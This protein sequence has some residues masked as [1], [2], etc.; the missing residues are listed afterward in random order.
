M[1]DARS[2]DNLITILKADS[3]IITL[4][5]NRVYIGHAP[6]SAVL[7]FIVATLTGSDELQVLNGT[8]G[9]R[10][11]EYDIDCAAARSV[12]AENISGAVRAALTNYTGTVNGDTVHAVTVNA[13]TCDYEAPQSG[14]EIGTHTATIDVAI[15]YAPV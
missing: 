7:P 2:S 6:Q 13:E 9:S 8:T 4:V 11:L 5:G 14:D 1:T 3:E 10:I 15:H 12:T